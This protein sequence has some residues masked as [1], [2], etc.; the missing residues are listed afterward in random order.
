[1]ANIKTKW[2]LVIGG[3]LHAG[4]SIKWRNR[5]PSFSSRLKNKSQ[6]GD[7]HVALFVEFLL[8]H[9]IGN[10]FFIES[11]LNNAYS[12]ISLTQQLGSRESVLRPVPTL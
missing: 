11:Q 12:H 9:F 10:L 6:D 3:M 1:M 7:M 4:K 8:L 5:L 2:G